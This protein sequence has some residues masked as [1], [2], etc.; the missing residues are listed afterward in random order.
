M[1]EKKTKKIKASHEQS[2]IEKIFESGLWYSRFII[3]L[4][5]IFGLLSFLILFLI[6]SLKIVEVIIFIISSIIASGVHFDEYHKTILIPIIS[7]IDLYLIGVVLLIFSFGLYELFISQVDIARRENDTLNALEI[8]SL[9]ELKNNITKVVIIVLVVKFFEGV[10]TLDYKTP[11][12]MGYLAL[13]I[14]AISLGLYFLHKSKEKKE[15]KKY[16]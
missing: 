5:V 15:K 13:S 11:L 1:E 9:D 3:I 8:H 16:L 12:D 4:A 10:L 7:A 6:A 2:F 14:F